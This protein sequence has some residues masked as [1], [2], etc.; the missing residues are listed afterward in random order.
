MDAVFSE[1]YSVVMGLPQPQKAAAM[2]CAVYGAYRVVQWTYR[3]VLTLLCMSPLC[4]G[5]RFTA[6]L[7]RAYSFEGKKYF[8][9]DGVSDEIAAR[10]EKGANVSLGVRRW[11]LARLSVARRR[12]AL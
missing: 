10:R 9:A 11:I 7:I 6:P 5:A 4:Y 8:N 3:R 12:S 2:G 1:V